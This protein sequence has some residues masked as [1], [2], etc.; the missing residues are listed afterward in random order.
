MLGLKLIYVSKMAHCQCVSRGSVHTVE[1][2]VISSGITPCHHGYC[3]NSQLPGTK[4]YLFAP[5]S[6]GFENLNVV[7][8]L[9]TFIDFLCW[10]LSGGGGGGGGGG[11]AYNGSIY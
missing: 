4:F 8:I 3:S 5:K 2:Y 11:N 9:H 6:T 1:F 7:C 10:K